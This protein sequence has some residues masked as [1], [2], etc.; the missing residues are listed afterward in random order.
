MHELLRA[1][2]TGDLHAVKNLLK[3]SSLN[4][5]QMNN[6][7][8]TPFWMACAIAH[9]EIVEQLMQDH[10]VDITKPDQDGQTPFWM[11]CA[12]A[13]QEIMQLFAK[14]PR[15]TIDRDEM[16]EKAEGYDA[17]EIVECLKKLELSDT[18]SSTPKISEEYAAMHPKTLTETLLRFSAAGKR[19][20]VEII[21]KV[22]KEKTKQP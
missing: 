22:M 20:E 1:C 3:D 16:I 21:T 14:D 10:R 13:H 17:A 12:I 18:P 9:Q 11:A 4:V 5:N 15:V 7:G 19:E 6:A 2:E 8:Q